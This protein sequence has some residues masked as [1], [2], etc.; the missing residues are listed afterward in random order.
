[1]N[2]SKKIIWLVYILFE[3]LRAV[4]FL[5]CGCWATP[6]HAI[7]LQRLKNICFHQDV[8]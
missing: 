1:M 7:Y 6:L 4:F 8:L 2:N 5:V 3:T